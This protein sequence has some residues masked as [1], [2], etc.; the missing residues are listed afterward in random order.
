MEIDLPY[1]LELRSYQTNKWNKAVHEGVNRIM[2]VWPR[3]NGKDLV[4]L[5]ILIAR[6]HQR[7]GLYFYMA[8]F[9]TQVRSIIWKGTDGSGKRFLDYIPRELISNKHE[10]DLRI[11]LKNGSQL[12]FVG[13]DNI[14]SIV[15]NNPVGVVFTE[16]SLHK[17]QAWHYLRPV[18]AENGGWA[19]FNGTPRGLNHMFQQYQLA[20]RDPENWYVEYFT[21]DDTGIPSLKAIDIDRRSGMPESLI[22]QEYYCSWTSSSEE[23]LIPLDIIQPRLTTQLPHDY[24]SIIPQPPRIMGCDVAYATLGDQA[25]I[26]KRQGRLLH[27]LLKFQGF[28][29]MSFSS[30]IAREI[31]E[32][33]PDAVFVDSG[34]GEGVISRLHQL[35]YSSLVIPVHFS[36]KPF[37]DLYA[38]KKAEIWCRTR[39]WIADDDTPPLLPHDEQMIAALSA[40]TFEINERGFIQ[41]EGKKS[42]R[43]RNVKSTDEADAIALTFSEDI[44]PGEYA[45][46]G[47]EYSSIMVQ[48]QKREY[49]PMNYF[50]KDKEERYASSSV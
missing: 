41:I 32:W 26:A 30:R 23:T 27:P 47:N 42:L 14:D 19:T 44:E 7:R 34:R 49:D 16:F 13:S 39:D 1:E 31:E 6:A 15:G 40:P 25:V 48:S 11:E 46:L 24:L 29:N 20:L 36:G 5:N 43:K 50:N 37:S 4:D 9:Y 28:D 17:P 35:G 33:R 45:Y 10:T 3:R 38:N 2:S 21:R 22:Q 12:R 18:L 8:P